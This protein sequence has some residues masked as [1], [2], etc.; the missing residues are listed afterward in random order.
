HIAIYKLGAVALPL[1][2]LFGIDAL[3][4]RL[5]NSGATALIANA[6]GVAHIAEIRNDLPD[7]KL[8][9]S[10][11]GAG[12]GVLDFAA[13]LARAASDFTAVDTSADDPAM[14][15]YTSGTKARCTPIVSCSGT[16]PVSRR[17]TISSRSRATAS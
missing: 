7:L 11:D 9:L 15:V 8:V 17:I 14:M 3:R 16:C 13:A 4:Y 12:D 5:Q 10:L 6:Q 1:A 2:V